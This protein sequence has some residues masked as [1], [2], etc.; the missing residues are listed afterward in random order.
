VIKMHNIRQTS[1]QTATNFA[2]FLNLS[3]MDDSSED[4]IKIEDL[5]ILPYLTSGENSLFSKDPETSAQSYRQSYDDFL[6]GAGCS[7]TAQYTEVSPETAKRVIGGLHITN[8]Q[9]SP[10]RFGQGGEKDDSPTMAD[11]V[12]D[13]HRPINLSPI[14]FPRRPGFPK[15]S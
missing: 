8:L 4:S 11:M 7:P 13:F 10:R 5:S 15:V 1:Q 14:H 3:E 9:E 12:Q 6:G 2:P